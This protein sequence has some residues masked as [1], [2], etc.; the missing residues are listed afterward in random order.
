MAAS[1]HAP[2]GSHLVA[3]FHLM[4]AVICGEPVWSSGKALGW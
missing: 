4:V 1:S 3:S 2:G